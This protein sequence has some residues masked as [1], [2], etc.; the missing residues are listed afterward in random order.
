MS[1]DGIHTFTFDGAS[2]RGRIV[3]L[4]ETWQTIRTRHDYPPNAERL[5]GEMLAIVAM[6]A[7]G[8]KFDGSV[9]LQT[10]GDGVIRTAMVECADRTRLRGIVRSA[11]PRDGA[12]TSTNGAQLAITLKPHRGEMYQGIVPME[13]P[14][15]ARAVEGYFANSE[16]LPTRIWAAA[17]PQVV[18]GL[19]LQRMPDARVAGLEPIHATDTDWLRLQTLAANVDDRDLLDTPADRLLMRLF[20][21]EAVRLQA[22]RPLEFGCSCSRERTANVL[23][24][25]GRDE[26]E[27]ILAQEG[28]ID[29]RCEFCGQHYGYDPIDAR[30]LFEPLAH[31]PPG[32]PQ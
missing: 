25:M 11:E 12:A 16:Q 5:L 19:L 17:S 6:L 26:I 32:T 23:R 2:V 1:D 18:A 22:A 28:R 3:R 13:R 8:I 21:A 4:T 15:I 7:H 31:E 29:V 27:D 14:S 20:P 9:I 30:L 24:I 10:R